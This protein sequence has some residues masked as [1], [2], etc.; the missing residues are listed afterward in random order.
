MLL[1]SGAMPHDLVLWMQGHPYLKPGFCPS[2]CTDLGALSTWSCSLR[3][4]AGYQRDL[5][6]LIFT[7]DYVQ[8]LE[9]LLDSLELGPGYGFAPCQRH[10]ADRQSPPQRHRPGHLLDSF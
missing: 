8:F 2:K 10:F 4:R 1:V 5:V 7:Q 3:A 6:G 9:G